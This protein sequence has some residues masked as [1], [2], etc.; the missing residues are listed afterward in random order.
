MKNLKKSPFTKALSLVLALIFILSAFAGCGGEKEEEATEAPTTTEATTA[1]PVIVRNPLTGE[2]GYDEALLGNRPVF[3]V[4]ENHP[5]ARPQ[6]GLTSSDIV[7]EMV[8][9]GGITRM[10]L[11]YADSSR[12]PSKVGPTRSA[13][14]YF[15]ELAQG[16]DGIFVHFGGSTYAYT[17]LKN[18][19]IDDIDGKY[20][21]K[22]FSRDRSRGVA[23]EHTA[24][25]TVEKVT[26]AI[27]SNGFRTTLKDGYESPFKFNETTEK[28]ST[29]ECNSIV[30]SFS[31]SYTYTYTYSAED[32]VYYSALNGKAFKDS[33]GNQQNF[34]NIIVCYTN[35]SNISGDSKNRVTFDLS[36]G[37]G[38]YVSNGTYESITWKKGN[39]SD[40]MKFYDADGNELSLNAGRTYI[41]IVDN[42]REAKTVIA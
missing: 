37:N 42:D 6:W 11:M 13:R 31:S 26:A 40:M 27:K 20:D 24:Y 8:A 36:K 19:D 25:T 34:E 29:G 18:N 1:A 23:T 7:W 21:S 4:V 16:F 17:Y 32:N 15:L 2:A 38:T 30:V 9:E 10:L 39:G 12:L 5:D 14:H 35:I 3:V 33:D 28:L 22:T 41:A